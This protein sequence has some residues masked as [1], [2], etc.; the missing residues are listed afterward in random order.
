MF[1]QHL[2][3][4]Y[5]KSLKDVEKA[6]RSYEAY[7]NNK[8]NETTTSGKILKEVEISN[9]TIA[10]YMDM[11]NTIIKYNSNDVFGTLHRL[12]LFPKI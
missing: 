11:E 10:D 9:L 6:K 2:I 7:F 5:Q 3:H 1:S 12:P 4:L 8:T